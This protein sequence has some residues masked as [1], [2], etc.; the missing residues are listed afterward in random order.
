ML[1]FIKKVSKEKTVS[2]NFSHA[3]FYLSFMHD[4]RAM[5][6]LVWLYTVHSERSSL[7]LQDDLTHLSV[8]FKGENLCLYSSKYGNC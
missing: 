3:L 8:K 6:A 5:Q 4:D 1:C 7:A 2:V